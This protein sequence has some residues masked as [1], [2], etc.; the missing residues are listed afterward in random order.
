MSFGIYALGF[1]IMIIGL[2]YL[3]HIMHIPQAYIGAGAIILVGM[4]ILMGVQNT[5]QR[6]KS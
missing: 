2:V 4:G 5:R 1:A 6:D 3:A